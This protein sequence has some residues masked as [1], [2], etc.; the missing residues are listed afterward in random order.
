MKKSFPENIISRRVLCFCF[1]LKLETRLTGPCDNLL[2][3]INSHQDYGSSSGSI[4]VMIWIG[5]K[6]WVRLGVWARVRLMVTKRSLASNIDQKFVESY[7]EY[8]R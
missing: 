7:K 1:H 5:A 3:M 4:G 8:A 2:S 6:V